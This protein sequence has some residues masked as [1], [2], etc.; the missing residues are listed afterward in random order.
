M[1]CIATSM[2]PNRFRSKAESR[3]RDALLPRVRRA[4]PNRHGA[5][6]VNKPTD[7]ER[8]DAAEAKLAEIVARNFEQTA[9]DLMADKTMTLNAK[10]GKLLRAFADVLE[11][12]APISVWEPLFTRI[13]PAAAQAK[14]PAEQPEHR[15]RRHLVHDTANCRLFAD[16]DA[17][18]VKLSLFFRGVP[19]R[20]HA[21]G[22]IKDGEPLGEFSGA[23]AG[24]ITLVREDARDRLTL[25]NALFGLETMAFS[26]THSGEDWARERRVDF[27]TLH[28]SVLELTDTRAP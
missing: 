20:R 6:T 4:V 3:Q 27:E 25:S 19:K 15:K 13:F 11:S 5:A 24:S 28:L 9:R 2:D 10:C 8:A 26:P 14:T 1:T 22:M 16:V 18:G 12:G 21:V 7:K 23:S 17:H